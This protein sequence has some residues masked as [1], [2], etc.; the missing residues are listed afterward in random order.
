MSSAAN[1]GADYD[2]FRRNYLT[3]FLCGAAS[4]WLKGPYIYRLYEAR[5]F[6]PEQITFL[7]AS[8]YVSSAAF[9][10]V[11]GALCDAFG[12]RRMCLVFCGLYTVHCL[13]H[14]FSSFTMLLVARAISGVATALLFCA[15]EACL[16]A[17]HA[18]LFSSTN[19]SD[20]FSLQTQG[21]A[22]VAVVAGLVAQGSVEVGGYAAPFV[23][24]VPLLTCCAL[25]VAQWSENVGSKS[26]ED[27]SVSTSLMK[28]QSVAAAVFSSMDS[29]V[30]RVGI[31]QC[32]FEGSMH[33][34][35][36]LWT[37]CL[38]RGVNR[39]PHGLVFSVY[40]ICMMIGGKQSRSSSRM[41]PSLGL[42][43][44]IASCSLMVPRFVEDLWCNLAA[45]CAFEWCCGCYFPQIATLRSRH[46]CEKSRGATISLF[47]VP[48]NIIVVV[49]L[50]WGRTQPPEMML[51]SASG[52]L[53]TASV[54][55]YT[56]PRNSVEVN[57]HADPRKS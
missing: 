10:L 4:D 47:R 30:L 53:A 48:L 6:S 23:V 57:G 46:F 39:L 55:F 50:V 17:E 37:P 42:V 35:I 26:K 21:N 5:G 45:F 2:V 16:V 7:F 56:L 43:F 19:L 20:I 36:F 8:G 31:M 52:A 40:M 54:A 3:A 28:M 38:Q 29:I 34:F 1:E 14:V 13:L 51:M 27:L 15:F 44:V 33:I 12:R 11:A 18:R 49:V 41:R 32:L 24:A 22:L 9:G 25:L